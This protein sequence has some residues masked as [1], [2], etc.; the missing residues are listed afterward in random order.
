MKSSRYQH[1]SLTS[2]TIEQFQ[3]HKR[4][5]S[6]SGQFWFTEICYILYNTSISNHKIVRYSKQSR[7][8][9]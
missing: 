7:T 5:I 4:I 3:E 2:G 9:L 6:M 1:K 8:C